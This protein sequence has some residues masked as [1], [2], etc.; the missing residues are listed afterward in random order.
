MKNVFCIALFLVSNVFA[1][2]NPLL[3]FKPLENYIWIAE[4]KWGDGS[5]FKQ[6]L[7]FDFSLNNKLVKVET[8]GFT[9]VK[10]TEFGTRNHGIRQYDTNLKKIKF[11][12]FDVFG[13]CIQGTVDVDNKN[14]I[15]TYDYQSTIVTE[16]WIFVDDLTYQFIVGIFKNGEWK[17][18]FLET[19]FIGKPKIK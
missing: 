1:Q 5:T 17:K 18:K 9:N 7:S 3:I 4:G 8:K 15:Y 10:Q 13:N 16:K 12:E 19:K 14:I 6:E 11:W 2:K